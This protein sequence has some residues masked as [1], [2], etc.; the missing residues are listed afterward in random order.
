MTQHWTEDYKVIA[1]YDGNNAF[2]FIHLPSGTVLLETLVV[3]METLNGLMREFDTFGTIRP[4]WREWWAE[5][6][7]VWHPARSRPV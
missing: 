6:D 7:V 5:R 2:Q 4:N 3:S 1:G